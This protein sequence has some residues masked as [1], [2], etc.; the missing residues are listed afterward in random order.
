MNI[1]IVESG[2]K[3]KTLQKYLGEGWAVLATG[4]HVETLPY[5]RKVH[6][7][8]ATK[9]FWANR[10]GQ[11]PSPP[12]VKTERG[13]EA[14]ARILEVAGDEPVF[15]VATDPD[16]EGEFIAW[17]LDRLLGSRGPTHRVAFEEV[18]RE[19]VA[20]ALERP[21]QVDDR[22][23]DSALVRKFLDRLVGFR[24]SSMART[25]VPGGAVSMGRVQ[26]PTL[27]FIVERELEREAHVPIP[28]F[29][30]RAL[31]L[32]VELEVRFHEPGDPDAWRDEVGKAHPVRTFDGEA[33][34]EAARALADAGEVTVT[35]T[36][37]TTRQRRPPEPFTTDALLQAAG[38]GF[39]WSPAKTSALASLLY[40]AGHI[41][42]IRTDSTRLAASAVEKA[43]DVVRRAF[44]DDHLGPTAPRAATATAATDATPAT[45]A[46]TIGTAA[47]AAGTAGTAAP[48][49]AAGTIQ[50]AHEA[51][52]PTRI[53]VEEPELDDADA[54]RLYRL[55]RAQTL[56]AQMPPSSRQGVSIEA[57]C[58]GLDRPLTGSVSWRTFAGWEAAYAEFLGDVATSPPG[59][60]LKAGAVWALDPGTDERE[61]PLLIQDQ[62]RPP[63]RFRPHT[64]I[65]AMKDAGIGRPSTY[66]R[67][68]EK[69]EEREYIVVDDGSVVPTERGR[70]VW[71]EA[72]PL[73]VRDGSEDEGPVELFSPEYTARMEAELD[74]IARGE[75]PA[76]AS[77]VE[78]RD[79]IRAM[80]DEAR[81]RKKAGRILPNQR[82]ML[83]RLLA[84][85]PAD[86][87][88]AHEDRLPELSYREARELIDQIREQGVKPAPTEKQMDYLQELV[89]DL[90]LDDDELEELT[91]VRSLDHVRN[92]DQ[93]SAAI[94]ELKRVHDERRPPSEKQRRFVADLVKE[95]GLTAAEAARLVD[96]TSLDQLTGG[97]EGT[98]SA[99]IDILQ[100]R[101][102]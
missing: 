89:A 35:G 84:A 58:D 2:A 14:V 42:Y 96:A 10:Q 23:V 50:D 70:L 41:T 90:E 5:D 45:A 29:E 95:A 85:A 21:R 24:T 56:A 92:S 97:R 68:L 25:V 8:D 6:G 64:V 71:T 55:V 77:W 27:G 61:N 43:R 28:F 98:A 74:R 15:W 7:K 17:S 49:T 53:E 47:A 57:G 93:A 13:D 18:T 100:A 36:R 46:G 37:S 34:G 20:A 69:L 39:G 101:Q 3:A 31:A 99:L 80:H 11:L 48:A 9:A 60:P 62:T 86:V 66:S 22:M 26:T 54:R 19:A 67:T 73:Y 76:P 82:T 78:W 79:E 33:A 88:T 16:R 87:R 75:V 12:W 32:G 52:R 38:A 94:T 81:A 59:I 83:E 51:I 72:A 4:G 30:V 91:G 44:G 40:E 1:L 65:K 63:A 102:E